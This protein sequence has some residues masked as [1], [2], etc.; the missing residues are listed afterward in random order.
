MY[1]VSFSLD[2]T[3]VVTTS[4]DDSAIVWDTETGEEL[5]TVEIGEGHRR[6]VVQPRRSPAGRPGTGRDGPGPRRVDRG[7]VH[8]APGSRRSRTAVPRSART[9]RGSLPPHVPY[10]DSAG[11][12]EVWE[13]ASGR[14]LCT[15]CLSDEDWISGWMFSPD[16]GRLAG[17]TGGTAAIW[18]AWTGDELVTISGHS[19]EV[20]GVSFSR[21]GTRIATGSEDGTARVWDAATGE[22][23]VRL[24]GHDGLVALVDFSPDGTRLLTGGGD[25]TARVWDISDTA[26]AEL[27]TQRVASDGASAAWRTTTTAHISS[28]ATRVEAGCSIRRPEPRLTPIG[29]AWNDA[30]FSPEGDRV[31]ASG[32]SAAL[33]DVVSGK[34]VRTLD[35]AGGGYRHRVQPGRFRRRDRPRTST[36]TSARGGRCCGTR[37]RAGA[38]GRSARRT[39][40]KKCRAS[41]SAPTGR[42]SP[43]SATGRRLEVWDVD[44]GDRLMSRQAH[45]GNGSDLAFLPDGRLVTV[46]GDGGAVWEVPS[47]TKLFSL[48]E[49]RQARRRG[50]QP[51]WNAHRDGGRGSN[52]DDLGRRDR[53][54]APR[55]GAAQRRHEHRVQP[56]RHRAGDRRRERDRPRLRPSGRRPRSPRP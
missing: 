24:S 10:V 17:R 11:R 55:T 22:E 32:D 19:G 30:S 37:P 20:F 3:R 47:G 33:T 23:L 49:R 45:P 27:W 2:W 35:V 41:R 43:S 26:G 48:V 14:R 12:A 16:G 5:F 52:G 51:G 15:R 13:V 4:D 31:A 8:D 29:L 40:A 34:V 46:G 38:C 21:D 6:G 53:W 18:D 9:A 54:E 56:R 36:R 42:C 28:P 50:R 1:S 7:P 25:G 44:T 39:P